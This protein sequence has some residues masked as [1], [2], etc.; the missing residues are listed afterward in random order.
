[1]PPALQQENESEKT[2]CL[3]V[4][5]YI[6]T[7]IILIFRCFD[8]NLKHQLPPTNHIVKRLTL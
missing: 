7:V 6:R 2:S 3:L 1:M 5:Y 4:V 8:S